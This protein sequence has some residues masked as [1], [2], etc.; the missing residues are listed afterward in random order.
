MNMQSFHLES[1]VEHEFF[2]MNFIHFDFIHVH[3]DSSLHNK[4][5]S[6]NMLFMSSKYS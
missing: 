4:E 3:L 5:Y 1:F 2:M 6:K